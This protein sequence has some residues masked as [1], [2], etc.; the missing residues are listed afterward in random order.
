MNK[1]LISTLASIVIAVVA[2][3]QAPQK[4]SFQAVVRDASNNL[5]ISS[6]VGMR[7]TILQ[8]SPTGTV[9][10]SE[11]QSPSTNANGLVSIEIGTGSVISGSFATIGWGLGPYF[12]KTETDPTGGTSYSISGTQQLMSVPYALYAETSGSSIAGP[13]GPTGNTGPAGPQGIPGNDGVDG[14][15]GATGA[16][17]PT[18]ATGIAGTNGTNGAT[19]ATGPT[20]DT[21]P[22]GIPGPTGP[23]GNS[24]IISTASGTASLNADNSTVGIYT[25]IP[26]LIDTI[27]VPAGFTHKILI[28]TDGGVQLNSGSTTAV[29]F[30]DVAIFINGIKS[31]SGRR[32]QVM[33]NSAMTYAIDAYSFST[34]ATL[35][36]GT[37]IIDVRAKKFSTTFSTC[38]VSSAASGST[39][40]GNPPI[41]GILNIFEFP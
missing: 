2:F 17:G 1:K 38:Y 28:Q 10:Y 37:Y 12:I 7:I 41:Q 13:T 3:A 35:S 24:P 6:P 5:L 26:G 27:I 31:G 39:L 23:S 25:V 34:A 22:Q 18:G 14:L 40:P 20:G 15:N 29:G 21:G 32:I 36:A 11:A 8:G 30:T 19:G 33:N 4:M 16:V 9:V